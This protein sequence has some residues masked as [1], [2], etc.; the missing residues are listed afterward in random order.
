MIGRSVTPF[1]SDLFAAVC[2]FGAS[3]FVIRL[4][5]A[6]PRGENQMKR[7]LSVIATVLLTAAA[8]TT[9]QAAG[10][11]SEAT[12]GP[13]AYARLK[14]LVGEWEADTGDRKSTRLNSSH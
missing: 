2:R 4:Q 11:K 10:P 9:V 3:S 13:A 14:T 8:T 6:T 5:H 1:R 12:A 7:H